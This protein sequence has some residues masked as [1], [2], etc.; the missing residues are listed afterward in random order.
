MEFLMFIQSI[1]HDTSSSLSFWYVIALFFSGGKRAALYVL[2]EDNL[3]IL[4]FLEFGIKAKKDEKPALFFPL[5]IWNCLHKTGIICSLKL[6]I[7]WRSHVD[8]SVCGNFFFFFFTTDWIYFKFT[9]LFR[10]Y[11][12]FLSL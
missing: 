10:F 9:G 3:F 7:H 2:S 12:F 1:D 6:R 8:L 11:Y 5:L 4:S